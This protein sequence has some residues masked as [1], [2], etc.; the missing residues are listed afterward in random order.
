MRY[1]SKRYKFKLS[2]DLRWVKDGESPARKALCLSGA[3]KRVWGRHRMLIS[4][5]CYFRKRVRVK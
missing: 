5:W 4:G 1:Y 2:K 3:V